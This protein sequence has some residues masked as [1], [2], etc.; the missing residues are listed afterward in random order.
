MRWSTASRSAASTPISSTTCSNAIGSSWPDSAF[1]DGLSQPS[2][3]AFDY[4]SER[5]ETIIRAYTVYSDLWLCD[6]EGNVV[7][8]ARGNLYPN[9]RNK[10]VANRPWFRKGL[11]LHTGDDFLAED[12]ASEPMLNNAA[13]ERW[14]LD[15]V[16]ITGTGAG[17]SYVPGYA[18]RQVSGTSVSVTGLVEDTAY[19]FRVRA[20]SPAC[21]SGNSPTGTVTRVMMTSR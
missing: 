5:L 12:V 16:E 18:D 11:S 4:A 21:E 17:A 14:T 19:Y 1:V 10:N 3:R 2:P 8:S 9:V 15:D 6:L 20:E 13:G 7:A